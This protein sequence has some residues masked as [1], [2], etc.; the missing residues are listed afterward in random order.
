M[1]GP[2]CAEKDSPQRITAG[3]EYSAKLVS[4]EASEKTLA[5][6]PEVQILS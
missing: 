1:L 3:Q 2:L 5:R 4:D 6:R